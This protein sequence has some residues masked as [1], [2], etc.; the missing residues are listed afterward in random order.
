MAVSGSRTTPARCIEAWSPL[1]TT[2]P[3]RYRASPAPHRGRVL[4]PSGPQAVLVPPFLAFRPTR[5]SEL[6]VFRT[7]S[8]QR[9]IRWR[10]HVVRTKAAW[11]LRHPLDLRLLPLRSR[12]PSRSPGYLPKTPRG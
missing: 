11:L 8:L 12:G 6:L 9:E 10:C 3:S 5:E 2:S 7:D 1:Q 4:D